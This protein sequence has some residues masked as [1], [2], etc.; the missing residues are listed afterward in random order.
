[1]PNLTAAVRN[2]LHPP[3]EHCYLRAKCSVRG[4]ELACQDWTNYVNLKVWHTAHER[5][6]NRARYLKSFP[7]TDEDF[8]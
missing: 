4:M 3:C 7:T 6:P 2:Q 5:V 1:M 8:Q